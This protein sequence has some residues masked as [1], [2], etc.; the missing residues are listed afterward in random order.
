MKQTD[1]L[2]TAIMIK[3]IIPQC[4]VGEI[5]YLFLK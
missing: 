2:P 5:A 1:P 4:G 3:D